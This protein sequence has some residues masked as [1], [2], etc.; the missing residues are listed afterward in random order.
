[1]SAT[2]YRGFIIRVQPTPAGGFD[3]FAYTEEAKPVSVC[4]TY[5]L[6]APESGVRRGGA[7]GA[8]GPRVDR[9]VD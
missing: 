6:G 8:G 7:G 9:S 2:S 3:W 4:L 5:N 1:M